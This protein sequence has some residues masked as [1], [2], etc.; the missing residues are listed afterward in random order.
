MV[1]EGLGVSLVPSLTLNRRPKHIRAIRLVPRRYRTI[2][3]LL[4]P[5]G[6]PSPALTRWLDLVRAKAPAVLREALAEV[7]SER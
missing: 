4:P 3:V 2:G 1:G 7:K 6:V 5:D